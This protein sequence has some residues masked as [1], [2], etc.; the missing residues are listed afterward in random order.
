MAARRFEIP[1]ESIP[2]NSLARTPDPTRCALNAESMRDGEPPGAG[3]TQKV[4]N[5]WHAEN[6]QPTRLLLVGTSKAEPCGPACC[7]DSVLSRMRRPTLGATEH[8]R[9]FAPLR[10]PALAG[11]VRPRRAMTPRLLRGAWD[12]CSGEG[13]VGSTGSR[14]ATTS[15]TVVLKTFG[16]KGPPNS[17]FSHTETCGRGFPEGH[18]ELP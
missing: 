3:Q 10:P 6:M 16:F 5:G 11:T 9:F 18:G 17:L 14:R 15:F 8:A 4:T 1:R 12:T 7:L 13:V 2:R